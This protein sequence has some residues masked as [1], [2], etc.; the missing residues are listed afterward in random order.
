MIADKTL[1]TSKKRQRISI[2]I[3]DVSSSSKNSLDKSANNNSILN[4]NK[5]KKDDVFLPPSDL[6]GNVLHKN[7]SKIKEMKDSAQLF[8]DKNAV[9]LW[10][11]FSES[12]Y[13]LL[14]GLLNRDDVF[15]AGKTIRK[16]LQHTGYLT[17]TGEM[18]NKSMGGMLDI[19]SGTFISGTD[20]YNTDS[21]NIDKKFKEVCNL[22]EIKV[23]ESKLSYII[24][25]IVIAATALNT[26]QT[27]A[28]FL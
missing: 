8:L 6:G 18:K 21:L 26:K 25:Y 1:N 16:S 7:D 24:L 28:S 15:K 13:L 2:S 5:N 10:K 11:L 12:G 9:G 17:Y 14:R 23:S 27:V 20:K 19:N 4:D 3:Q 22:K